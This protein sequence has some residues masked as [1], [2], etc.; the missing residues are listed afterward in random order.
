MTDL[1]ALAAD[2]PVSTEPVHRIVVVAEPNELAHH[3]QAWE[4]LVEQAAEPNAFYE[5]WALLPALRHLRGGQA[6]RV[7]LFF[8]D[9]ERTVLDG[10]L[11][12]FG[13]SYGRLLACLHTYRHR[14]CFSAEPLLRRGRESEVAHSFVAWLR[15]FRYPLLSLRGL[16]AEGAWLRELRPALQRCGL[17]FLPA[18]PVQRAL[19]S[20]EGGLEAFLE[21]TPAKKRK[22]YRRLRER[23]AGLGDLQVDVLRPGARDLQSWLDAFVALELKGWKGREGTALGSRPECRRFFEETARSAHERGLLVMMRMSLDGKPLAMLCDLLAPPGR[24]AFKTAYDEDYS[25][26]AP[27][28]L[29]EIENATLSFQDPR[30][31]EWL[32]SCAAPDNALLNR[33]YPGRRSLSDLTICP[34]GL[35][36]AGLM[37]SSGLKRLRQRWRLEE[38]GRTA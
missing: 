32:D 16:D 34:Q 11:P 35:A 9:S 2:L 24:Y 10:I 18:A 5:P 29:L 36:W 38:A 17:R 33:L 15:Q 21:R 28:V 23:L 1:S 4:Q 8:R 25:R 27:G 19:L 30:G 3:L 37:A 13:R 14:Y 26:F 7:L 22:E 12:L 6:V 20:L 31:V